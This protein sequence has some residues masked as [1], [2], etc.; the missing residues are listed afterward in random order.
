MSRILLTVWKNFLTIYDK[1]C[2][3]FKDLSGILI[4][5]EPNFEKIEPRKRTSK[6]RSF[7]SIVQ[8]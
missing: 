6:T 5:F 7:L 2:V 4:I 1:F 3:E 8:S